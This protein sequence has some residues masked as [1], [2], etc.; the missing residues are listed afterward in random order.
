MRQIAVQFPSIT[1]SNRLRE[2]IMASQ[3]GAGRVS[4]MR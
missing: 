3:S 4:V 2:A 1:Q